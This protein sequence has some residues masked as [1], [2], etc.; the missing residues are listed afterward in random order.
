MS[1]TLTHQDGEAF[2]EELSQGRRRIRVK[3]TDDKIFS[4]QKEWETAYPTDLISHILKIKGAAWVCDEI[5][6]EEDAAYVRKCLENDLFA[7]L[8]PE[9]F[10]GKRILDFGC[11][12]GASTAILARMFPDAEIV[13]VELFEPLLSIARKRIEHYNFSNARLYQSPD[14][15]NLPENIGQFDFVI[16]SAVYEHLLPT[17]RKILMPKIWSAIRDGGY[18]FLN[19]TP[20]RFF[21]IEAHTTRLP[22]INYLP[23]HLTRLAAVKF[24]RR[25]NPNESWESLLRQGIRGG[26]V[27][28]IYRSLS[29]DENSVRLLE[30]K[31]L[32]LRDR[33]DLWYLTTNKENLGAFKAAAKIIL[34]GLKTLTGIV[35]V[36]DLSLVFKKTKRAEN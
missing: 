7:Y 1:T 21:P 19:Q 4:P 11:G 26:S 10:K 28:E 14:G 31:N 17:E 22:F 34:K 33:I 24:S 6:R 36:Q 13:G 20:N 15:T 30:P 32:G 5:M 16:M 27:K 35:L 12:S 29:A 3:L 9:D 8:N 25:V 23:D 18:L 2:I